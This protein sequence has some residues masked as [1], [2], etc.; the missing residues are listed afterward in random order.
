MK[1]SWAYGYPLKKFLTLAF[2][3]NLLVGL[4]AFLV[5]PLLPPQIPLYYGMAESE[6][7]V[8]PSLALVIP[9]LASL[10]ILGLNFTLGFFIEDEFLKKTLVLSGLVA[11]FFATIATLRIIFLV[12]S[13]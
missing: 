8:A 1:T 13:I 12:G 2:V 6:R 5:Q 11:S 3:I 7:S 4:T 9:T 10:G